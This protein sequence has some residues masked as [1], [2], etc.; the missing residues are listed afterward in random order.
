AAVCRPPLER[1]IR[2]EPRGVLDAGHWRI[3]RQ[4]PV[5]DERRRRDDYRIGLPGHLPGDDAP[6]RP[7]PD[8]PFDECAGPD[9][10]SHALEQ[11][12]RDPAVA[13]RPR[14][15]AELAA[16]ARGEVVY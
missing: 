1:Q 11:A 10:V 9:D 3:R 15:R 6:A 5:G 13:L 16:L 12:R 8:D 4:D 7:G 2:R 14:E